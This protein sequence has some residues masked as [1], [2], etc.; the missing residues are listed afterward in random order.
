[1]CCDEPYEHEVLSS[2]KDD[3]GGMCK[4]EGRFQK[5]RITGLAGGHGMFSFY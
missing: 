2:L 5:I 4:S 1:M 3:E